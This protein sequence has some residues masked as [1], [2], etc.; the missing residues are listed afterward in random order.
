MEA[1]GFSRFPGHQVQHPCFPMDIHGG[2]P[3]QFGQSEGIGGP[4]INPFLIAHPERNQ[5]IVRDAT[6]IEPF[7]E[8]GCF[9]QL[10]AASLV[11]VTTNPSVI[12]PPES[13]FD[14]RSLALQLVA[15]PLV[16]GACGMYVNESM[17]GIV[18]KRLFKDQQ[19]LC[20]YASS[21]ESQFLL[22]SEICRH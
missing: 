21:L 3:Y 13:G 4:C 9:L 14:P 11:G 20:Y 6:K 5:D 22:F 2:L 17:S 18:K 10:T 12:L 1:V 7:I 19:F 8:R 16:L 15:T